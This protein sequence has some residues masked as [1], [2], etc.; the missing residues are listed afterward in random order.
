MMI[1]NLTSKMSLTGNI[2]LDGIIATT[3]F[4]MLKSWFSVV[5]EFL[6]TLT[7]FIWIRLRYA[8]GKYALKKLGSEVIITSEFTKRNEL[9]IFLQNHVMTQ[10]SDEIKHESK[11]LW[12]RKFFDPDYWL[13]FS[14]TKSNETECNF[15]Q[16]YL[17]ANSIETTSKSG[18]TSKSK[19]HFKF[20][21]DNKRFIFSFWYFDPSMYRHYWK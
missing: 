6:T 14:Y 4:G 12:F 16:S 15:D 3:I 18:T 10:T 9:Y 19:V 20:T 1:E 17:N 11:R 21:K 5:S 2:Y 7:K 8:I 13:N